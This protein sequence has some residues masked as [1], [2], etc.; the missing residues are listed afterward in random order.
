MDFEKVVADLMLSTFG[1]AAFGVSERGPWAE[2]MQLHAQTPWSPA[3]QLIMDLCVLT[4]RQVDPE[5][6][7]AVVAEPFDRALEGISR[8]FVDP[9]WRFNAK[10]TPNGWKV[11][12]AI[13]TVKSYFREM[14]SRSLAQI[15]LED[16][17]GTAVAPS[18]AGYSY[19][20]ALLDSKEKISKEDIADSCR[21]A[22]VAGV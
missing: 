15:T 22:L 20:R 13:A 16:M 12:R 21:T 5:E 11:A 2:T 19:I 4:V 10:L 8:R 6:L 3:I 18:R 14:V 7:I 9:L 17:E 1:E